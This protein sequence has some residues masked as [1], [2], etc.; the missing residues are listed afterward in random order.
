MGLDK[1]IRQPHRR[2]T[3]ARGRW[4]R[5]PALRA[6]LRT[7]VRAYEPLSGEHL[8]GD[9]ELQVRLHHGFLQRH[10]GVV[11][12]VGHLVCHYLGRC[13]VD[14]LRQQKL[15]KGFHQ[16]GHQLC[17]AE[18]DV[19]QQH[20]RAVRVLPREFGGLHHAAPQAVH[21]GTQRRHKLTQSM[22]EVARAA[23]RELRNFLVDS[24]SDRCNSRGLE[25]C[26]ASEHRQGAYAEEALLDARHASARCANHLLQGQ[27]L[28]RPGSSLRMCD[29][30]FHALDGA[31]ER[32]ACCA[33]CSGAAKHRNAVDTFGRH[34][35]IQKRGTHRHK[36]V[37]DLNHLRHCCGLR[38]FARGRF[39]TA[40][41]AAAL[42]H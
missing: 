30:M 10:E 34:V 41:A 39:A 21:G 6:V 23:T 9:F 15:R 31:R 4:P 36:G 17:A 33:L 37:H 29:L 27:R 14:Y 28:P 19:A 2:R 16:L 32:S 42:R 8:R 13:R 20:Q 26:L 24:D 11:D 12:T 25:A 40:A 7:V 22:E 5:R 18:R 38:R 35:C 3:H 1:Q